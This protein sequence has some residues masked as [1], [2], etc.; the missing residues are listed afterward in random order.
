MKLLL[1][2]PLLPVLAIAWLALSPRRAELSTGWLVALVAAFPLMVATLVTSQEMALPDLLVQGS[3]A[4]VLDGGARASLLLFGG[5]WFV[6]GL[7][8]TRSGERGPPVTA[9]LITLSGALTLALARGGPLVYAGM[10]AVGYGIYAVMAGEQACPDRRPRGALIVLLV[11]SDLLV[12]ELLLSD[13]AH[14]AAGVGGH[15][16]VLAAI[17]LLLRAGVPPA[18][19][20]L[21]PALSAATRPT[22]VL[23]AAVPAGAAWQGG[24]KLLPTGAPDAAGVC[25]LLGL[26]GAVWATVAGLLQARERAT[27]GYAVAATSALLLLALPAGE[28][29]GAQLPWLVLCMLAACAAVPLLALQ[30]AGW[31]RDVVVALL[32]LAHG[33]A[34]GHAAVHAGTVL[35]AGID[36]LPSLVAVMA[37]LLLTVAVLRTEP[38][39]AVAGL[40]QARERATLGYAVAA[41]SA[42]LLLALPAG[43]GAGAQ[44][45][46][47]VLGMLAACAA[48]PLLALQAAGWLRD[49]VVALLLLAHGLAAGHAAVHAGTVLPA[50]IDLLPSLVAVMASLLLTVAVL[51]TEPWAAGAGEPTRLALFPMAMALTG[52]GLAWWAS[53]P[54]FAAA[55]TAPVGITL[56]LLWRRFSPARARG[57]LQPGDLLLPLQRAAARVVSTGRRLATQDLAHLRDAGQAFLLG[58]WD[59]AAWSRRVQHLDIRLRSWP[60][61]SLMMLAVALATA[62]LLAR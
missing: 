3:A 61:T 37:S 1:A 36:L 27:L 16:A 11:V 20:W 54:G 42:L 9:L 34:A 35:P 4:L 56:G 30:A 5:S 19:G 6:A 24:I 45:P 8:M 17:A 32:L 57:S 51:R 10:L 31:L 13:M 23:L 60:A 21:P 29:A 48:V 58:L 25:L 12:F 18:H 47:L 26:L 62:F 7:L 53:P 41:T 49:L 40:L 28:G 44:L 46:W 39:A 50:G 2:L 38:W 59:G 43:E 52:L 55:W 14:P 22:A 33:L 15:L